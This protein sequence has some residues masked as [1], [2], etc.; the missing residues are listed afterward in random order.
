MIVKVLSNN[1]NDDDLKK[2][3]YAKL[4]AILFDSHQ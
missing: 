4:N 1:K 3:K 2:K